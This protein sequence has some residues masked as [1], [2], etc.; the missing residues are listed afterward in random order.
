M[1][2]PG[3]RE[4]IV[5]L[6]RRIAAIE[7]RD[8]PLRRPARASG[9]ADALDHAAF[10]QNHPN[11]ENVIDSKKIERASSEKPVPIFSQRALAR[12][13]YQVVDSEGRRFWLYRE[14]LPGEDAG[15]ARWFLHGLF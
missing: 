6:R 15:S 2:P 12:D 5:L 11:A 3:A 1:P 8:G 9:E 7:A 4:R 10:E 14:G 13:Y